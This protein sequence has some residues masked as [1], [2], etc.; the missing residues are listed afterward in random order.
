M[1]ML[2]SSS[3][4]DSYTTQPSWPPPAGRDNA[5]AHGQLHRN[6]NT[7]QPLWSFD[8]PNEKIE[9]EASK[10]AHGA[11]TFRRVKQSSRLE[12][13]LGIESFS[14]S[15]LVKFSLSNGTL[16]MHKQ[17]DAGGLVYVGERSGVDRVGKHSNNG[18]PV[19]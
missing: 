17:M 5:D 2:M 12:S 6:S 14:Y 4:D 19:Q 10:I 18:G 9:D 1:L 7:M 11:G 13:H 3:T 8:S 15:W 16:A